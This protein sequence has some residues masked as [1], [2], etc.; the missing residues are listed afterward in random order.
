MPLS[1]LEYLRHILDEADYL[2]AKAQRLSR[3][4]FMGD[5]TVKRAFVRSIEIIGEAA[6]KVPVVLKQRYPS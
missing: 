1:P 4:Q 3:E 5:E 6:K 2:T